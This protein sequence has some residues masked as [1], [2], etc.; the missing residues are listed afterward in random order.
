MILIHEANLQ[1]RL[2]KATKTRTTKHKTLTTD[3]ESQKLA[4]SNHKPSVVTHNVEKFTAACAA[5]HVAKGN[6]ILSALGTPSL[7]HIL[8]CDTDFEHTCLRLIL[9]D[10]LHAMDVEN[11]NKTNKPFAHF[12]KILSHAESNVVFKIFQDEPDFASQT[13][14]PI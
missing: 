11:V 3:R 5:E 6:L 4:Y 1:I 9:H 8:T 2:K 7:D 12:H 13:S 14:I 10:Y